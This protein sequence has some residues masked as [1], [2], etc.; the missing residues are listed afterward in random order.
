V[1]ACGTFWPEYYL[2]HALPSRSISYNRRKHHLR[3]CLL[4][5]ERNPRFRNSIAKDA[6]ENLMARTATCSRSGINEYEVHDHRR[7]KHF[8]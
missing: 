2:T 1:A 7:E 4:S 5:P 3:H 8:G 6:T